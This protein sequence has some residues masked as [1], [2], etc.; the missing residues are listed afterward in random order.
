[1]N[2]FGKNLIW[3]RKARLPLS[4][5]WNRVEQITAPRSLTLNFC[6]GGLTPLM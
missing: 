4:R 5:I 1:M 3:P 6:R 2:A